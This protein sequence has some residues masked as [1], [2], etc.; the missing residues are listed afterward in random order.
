MEE[1]ML[2][3]TAALIALAASAAP[4]LVQAQAA[5]HR[6]DT[7][8]Y[9]VTVTNLTRGQQ[10]TPI[11]AVSHRDPLRLFQF[12][13]AASAE[14]Q[15]LA[16]EGNTG[17][18]VDLLATSRA[19]TQVLPGTGLTDPG[20]SS[21]FIIEGRPF[22][23]RLSLAAM[24]IPTNDTFVA[25]NAVDLPPAWKATTR[26]TGFVGHA[27]P[28]AW[29]EP[30]HAREVRKKPTLAAGKPSFAESHQLMLDLMPAAGREEPHMRTTIN[31]DDDLLAKA[32]KLTG[33][34][35]RSAMVREGLKA[36]IERES[37]RRLARLGGTQPNL[38]APHRRRQGS[39]S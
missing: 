32:A 24:L 25:L 16:E 33:S 38:R 17:P 12:G 34:L 27:L 1:P 5:L 6:A 39:S 19:V 2:K 18:F 20:A 15:A 36:L 14:L 8:R 7:A 3:P 37:A 28:S 11:L 23:E 4:T 35:D 13:A 30:V 22:G 21:T 9:E 31:I 29:A 10:F 26:R